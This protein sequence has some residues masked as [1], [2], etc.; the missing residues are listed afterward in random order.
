VPSPHDGTV[1]SVVD[2][3]GREYHYRAPVAASPGEIWTLGR[4]GRIGGD[5]EDSDL[6]TRDFGIT[7]PGP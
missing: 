3:W 7:L 5:G 2:P 6:S 4:D 1:L